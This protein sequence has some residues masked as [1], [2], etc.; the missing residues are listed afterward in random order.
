MNT[1]RVPAE[2]TLTETKTQSADDEYT[3][4]GEMQ[5]EAVSYEYGGYRVRVWFHGERT[6]VQC[7][8]ALA[9]RRRE[10]CLSLSF[11]A[12]NKK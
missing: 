11:A 10:G 1:G 2:H 9:E 5:K 3:E 4:S 7:I 8:T 6:L 12:D